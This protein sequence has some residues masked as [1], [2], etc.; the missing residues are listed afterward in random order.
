MGDVLARRRL[1]TS[2]L[3]RLLD[4]PDADLAGI[5]GHVAASGAGASPAASTPAWWPTGT[6]RTWMWTP[7]WCGAP[8]R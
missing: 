1:L 8:V 7:G 2:A 4:H 6:T 3:A 5:P